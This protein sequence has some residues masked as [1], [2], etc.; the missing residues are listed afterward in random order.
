MVITAEERNGKPIEVR[1]ENE[2]CL[3]YLGDSFPED[4]PGQS[5]EECR[6]LEYP[7]RL[8]DGTYHILDAQMVDTVF[9]SKGGI[10]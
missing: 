9:P 1:T 4:A 3:K 10:R 7:F 8:G 2:E 6:R 5:L